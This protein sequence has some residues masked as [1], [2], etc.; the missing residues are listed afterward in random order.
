MRLLTAIM[1]SSFLLFSC[2]T[3]KQQKWGDGWIDVAVIEGMENYVDTTSI[4][5]KDGLCHAWVKTVYTTDSA[6][7]RY[8]DKIVN[9]YKE[10]TN[11][12]QKKIKK[13]QDFKYNISYRICDCANKRYRTVDI[14]DYTSDGKEIVHTKPDDKKPANW[15]NVGIDTMGDH[16]LYFICDFH[17]P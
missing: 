15:V 2:A 6:R 10:R 14:I 9:S 5:Y 12:V 11:E 7:L 17:A 3:Q 8:K 13:W 1:F 4:V 16:L